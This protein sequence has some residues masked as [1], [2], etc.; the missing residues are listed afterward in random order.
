MTISSDTKKALIIIPVLLIAG[1]FAYTTFFGASESP[2]ALVAD[3]GGNGILG[4]D[5]LLMVDK[6]Q[7]ISIDKSVFSGPLL[8]HLQDFSSPIAPEPKGKSNPFASVVI[9]KQK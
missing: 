6:L 1:Y 8:T 5:I 4:Q 9:V 7:G 3:V 2:D